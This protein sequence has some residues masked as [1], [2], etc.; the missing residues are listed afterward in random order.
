MPTTEAPNATA[1][2]RIGPNSAPDAA[3]L[4]SSFESWGRYP[5]YQ[6]HVVPMHWQQ[7]FP[8][9]IAGLH[10]GVLP[11][12][13]GRSYGDSCLLKDGNLVL[14]TGMN[15]LLA[16]APATGILPAEAGIT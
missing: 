15:R 6:A 3:P 2:S 14:T 4:D 1:A 10:N 8:A 5:Q 12:G 11:V 9:N 13:M 7:D 16:F